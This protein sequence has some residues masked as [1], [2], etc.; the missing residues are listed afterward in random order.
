M[1]PRTEFSVDQIREKGRKDILYL[2]EG[3]GLS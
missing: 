2:L 1:A 3:V